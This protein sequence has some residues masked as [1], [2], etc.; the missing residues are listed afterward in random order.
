MD[1]SKQKSAG[2]RLNQIDRWAKKG[3]NKYIQGYWFYKTIH[4]WY[5]KHV[6][7]VLLERVEQ[8]VLDIGHYL[9]K[10]IFIFTPVLSW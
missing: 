7:S 9:T 5:N 1:K 8:H 4:I 6:L 10:V 2:L 3:K